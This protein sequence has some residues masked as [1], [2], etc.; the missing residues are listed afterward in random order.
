MSIFVELQQLR[1]EALTT[2]Q[3]VQYSI[4]G[5]VIGE[6]QRVQ[7]HGDVPD[8]TVIKV[9]KK[10]IEGNNSTISVITDSA[11]ISKLEEENKVLNALLPKQLTKD[12]L[13]KI[14][15]EAVQNDPTMKDKKNMFPY[16]KK[17]Y[18]GLYSGQDANQ[19]F[20]LL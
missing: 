6:I 3:K 7:P 10:L 4:Y 11:V 12:E 1:K 14:M 19:N 13:F 2:Q 20:D 18:A 5:L 15:Q 16:L 9:L 8:E 17:N